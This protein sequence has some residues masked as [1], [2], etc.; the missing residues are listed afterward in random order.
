MCLIQVP[1]SS[2]R[3][4]PLHTWSKRIHGRFRPVRNRNADSD[5]HV[6]ERELGPARIA[7]LNYCS[8]SYAGGAGAPNVASSPTTKPGWLPASPP[9]K[10]TKRA[11]YVP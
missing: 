6:N 5:A 4:I 11:K 10:S 8:G 9:K 1:P 3:T 2:L 7:L